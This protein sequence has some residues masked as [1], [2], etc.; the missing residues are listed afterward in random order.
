LPDLLPA[1]ARAYGVSFIADAYW[2]TPRVAGGPISGA[3]RRPL[4]EL[5]DSLAAHAYAWDQ[6]G[7]LVRLRSRTWHLDRPREVPVRLVRRWLSSVATLGDEQL[8]SLAGVAREAQLPP[9][10]GSAYPA[11]HALR[12]YASLTAAQ[13]DALARGKAIPAAELLPRQRAIFL[14]ALQEG[15]RLDSPPIRLASMADGSLSLASGSL[16]RTGERQ[17][18][19]ISYR[20]EPAVAAQVPANAGAPEAGPQP[21]VSAARPPASSPQASNITRHPV[22]ELTLLLQFGP[23]LWES[24][25]VTV[26]PPRPSG[27]GVVDHG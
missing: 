5:L 17:G 18:G 4:P 9:E 6:R 11:R 15:H 14:A 3:E 1:L 12:L 20:T 22:T 13:R 21:G 2:S 24:V 10:F 19:K 27:A 26:T 25:F 7:R 16:V 23:G 8:Q